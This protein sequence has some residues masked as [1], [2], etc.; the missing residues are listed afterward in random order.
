MLKKV[1]VH[2]G[3]HARLYVAH[4]YYILINFNCK[5][6]QFD[7]D[8]IHHLQ[9]HAMQCASYRTAYIAC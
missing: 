8:T 9:K 1:Y 7:I 6:C 2:D 4:L 3:V 5:K